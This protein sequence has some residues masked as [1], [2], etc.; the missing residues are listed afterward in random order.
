MGCG[1]SSLDVVTENKVNDNLYE[2]YEEINLYAFNLYYYILTWKKRPDICYF[3]KIT[4]EE[5]Q[6]TEIKSLNNILEKM[7]D[8]HKDGIISLIKQ[9]DILIYIFCTNGVIITKNIN[10][11]N[12]YISNNINSIINICF[13]DISVISIPEKEYY[14]LYEIKRQ[15]KYFFDLNKK[16]IDFT[17]RNRLTNNGKIEQLS[18]Y[19]D[20]EEEIKKDEKDEEEIIKDIEI[21]I[22]W[23]HFNG[24]YMINNDDNFLG[25][26][27]KKKKNLEL[28]S[29]S[30]I[31]L[32]VNSI[33]N[34]DNNN[35][36][37]K[38]IKNYATKEK[39]K[40]GTNIQIYKNKRNT[41]N[42]KQ[43][44]N[45]DFS[46][47]TLKDKNKK[48]LNGSSS[49]ITMLSSERKTN[50]NSKNKEIKNAKNDYLLKFKKNKK[51]KI[52]S[53]SISNNLLFSNNLASNSKEEKLLLI[54]DTNRKMSSN[55]ISNTNRLNELNTIND[56]NKINSTNRN[57]NSN[58]INESNI[59]SDTNRINETSR[60]NNI[61]NLNNEDKQEKQ[62]EQENQEKQEKQD[63]Q[64]KKDIILPYEIKDKC[65]IINTNKLTRELNKELQEILFINYN[66]L[67]DIICNKKKKIESCYD[68]I[69]FHNTITDDKKKKMKKSKS[70]YILQ[71][72]KNDNSNILSLKC[73]MS[74]RQSMKTNNEFND[75]IIIINKNKEP[76]EK[77]KSFHKINKI[78]FTNYKFNMD[79]IYYLKELISMLVKYDDL[80]KIYINNNETII[81]NNTWKVLK[82]LL[83]ENFNIRWINLKNCNLNDYIFEMLMS[84][85]L[86]KRI[87]YLNI[88]NNKITNIGMYILN[89][90]L[91]KNQTLQVLDMSNNEKINTDGIKLILKALKLHPNIKKLNI[92]NMNL[93]GSGEYISDLL[94]ENKSI[95]ILIMK[96]DNFNNVDMEFIAKELSKRDTTL[97]ILDLSENI[98]IGNEGLR[99]IGKIIY[100][101]I[102]IKS[103]GLDGMNLSINN[104]LPIFNGIFKNKIIENYSMSKNEGLPMKG[105]LNFFQKNPQVKKINIIPWDREKEKENKFTEEQIFLLE[106]FH[107]KAPQVTLQGIT[108]IDN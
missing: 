25:I 35:P 44:K 41:V 100:N 39:D 38:E 63:N 1:T 65:L 27:E 94:R 104:Y 14:S 84:S 43:P 49:V 52:K 64:I 67:N 105:I 58:R 83:R 8:E 99:E 6:K 70:Q 10:K 4:E 62:E 28:S 103:I 2:D 75:Y 23:N 46:S 20:I 71:N 90:F 50:S 55:R 81:N 47:S 72:I 53:L 16:E 98:N 51:I 87:R 95:H 17:S 33:L 106:K 31:L 54:N 42:I 102:S 60:I 86:L 57:I 15:S 13:V 91:I 36:K 21:K 80:K 34:K 66:N 78:H 9:G 85:L 74:E 92:S 11:I 37:L 19:C 107:L 77:M 26:R 59:I 29:K 7:T 97:K 18:D 89:T 76:F 24:E 68:H 22:D 48:K 88:S 61:I 79:S 45:I 12:Y 5:F 40:D 108:F 56:I 82:Q 3:L 32:D 93:T 30:N 73:I 101:N 69:E 96:N